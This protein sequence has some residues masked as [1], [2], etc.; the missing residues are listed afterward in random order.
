MWIQHWDPESTSEYMQWKHVD[1]PPP[2]KFRTQSAVGIGNDNNFGDS[3][4]LHMVNY[5]SS[6]KVII[7][8]IMQKLCLNG[9]TSSVRNFGEN[10]H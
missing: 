9:M 1:C 5:L 7:V 6:K 3:E 4:E 8:N 10:C 2:T